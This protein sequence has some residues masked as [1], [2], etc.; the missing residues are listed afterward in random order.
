MVEVSVDRAM[1]LPLLAYCT[2]RN[3]VAVSSCLPQLPLDMVLL[4]P[5]SEPLVAKLLPPSLHTST[6]GQN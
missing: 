3:K 6:F 2:D 5:S 1:R 4:A